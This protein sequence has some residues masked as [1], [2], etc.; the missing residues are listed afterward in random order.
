ML[1]RADYWRLSSDDLSISCWWQCCLF[2]WPP[3]S[4]WYCH[5][6]LLTNQNHPRF[7]LVLCWHD[8]SETGIWCITYT[9][10]CITISIVNQSET[11]QIWL[12]N[13]KHFLCPHLRFNSDFQDFCERRHLFL[14]T[15]FYLLL[16]IYL[17][18]VESLSLSIP[19][20]LLFSV[21]YR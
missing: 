1:E 10:N 2:T 20:F 8:S 19:M 4:S 21:R 5:M 15:F 11:I 16:I 13:Q 14:F 12:T 7:L 18:P 6:F 17:K 9:H 3:G